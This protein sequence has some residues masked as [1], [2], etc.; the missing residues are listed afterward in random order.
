VNGPSD[1]DDD[2]DVLQAEVDAFAHELRESEAA[3]TA[4]RDRLATFEA[5]YR[6]WIAGRLATVEALQAELSALRGQRDLDAEARAAEAAR[7]ASQLTPKER[8]KSMMQ[9]VHPDRA[10]NDADRAEREDLSKRVNEA[11]DRQDMRKL[12]DL[13]AEIDRRTAA[14]FGPEERRRILDRVRAHFQGQLQG[15]RDEMATLRS[16]ALWALL[17]RSE[18]ARRE[19]RDLLAEQ[20]AELDELAAKLRREIDALREEAKWVASS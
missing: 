4:A 14:E 18:V 2:L 5:E 12:D 3:L 7:V 11:W 1:T 16:S 15:F 17:E 6:L 9:R 19:G 10:T 20:A 13:E 8:W